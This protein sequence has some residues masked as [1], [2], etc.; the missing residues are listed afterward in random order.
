MREDAVQIR[1]DS[2][3]SQLVRLNAALMGDVAIGHHGIVGRLEKLEGMAAEAPLLHRGIE[4]K[5]EGKVAV[6][7]ARLGDLIAEWGR[8]KGL[9]IG[10]AAGVSIAGG[11][12]GTWL[13]NAVLGGGG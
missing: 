9:A 7:D 3:D 1:L 10:L 5:A 8:F 13:F 12:G 2:I 11:F 4:E 6:V